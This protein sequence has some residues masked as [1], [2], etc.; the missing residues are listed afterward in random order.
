MQAVLGSG[1]DVVTL[2]TCCTSPPQAVLPKESV[3]Q[4]STADWR[5]SGVRSCICP[6]LLMHKGLFDPNLVHFV[7]AGLQRLRILER[8]KKATGAG[9]KHHE[10]DLVNQLMNLKYLSNVSRKCPSCGMATIKNEGCNKMTCVYCG[11]NWCWK[12]QQVSWRSSMR[13]GWV[14][15]V[16]AS[17]KVFCSISL[18][19]FGHGNPQ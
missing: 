6:F 4:N 9:E 18:T 7:A 5:E 14:V 17:G 15:M 10:M 8:R 3:T 16:T 12:C 13:C 2:L 19:R 1:T 11:S